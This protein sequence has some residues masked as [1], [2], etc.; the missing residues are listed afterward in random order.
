[1]GR[2]KSNFR[3]FFEIHLG[4]LLFRLLAAW[5]KRLSINSLGSYGQKMGA[6][7]VYLL[8]K[9]KKIALNNLN[10]ALG[11]E[12]SQEEIERICRDSFKNIGTDL[13]EISRFLDFED[14]YV[15]ERVTIEGK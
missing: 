13:L 15:K 2:R 4:Y 6:L 3:K 9:R 1:M 10:L 8:P 5:A 14:G 11:K 12:K 7:A